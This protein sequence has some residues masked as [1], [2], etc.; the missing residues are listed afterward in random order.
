MI[1]AYIDSH[2]DRFGVE[3][4][5]AVLTEHGISIA[6]STYYARKATPVSQT[7]P[8]EA[9]PINA[10]LTGHQENWGVYRVR[11]LWHAAR[12]AGLVQRGWDSPTGTDQL[13]VA[14]FSYV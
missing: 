3:P 8:E 6:P 4:I 13:W 11:K 1:V 5:C 2:R 12:R 7:E 9:Y 14:D 10:L